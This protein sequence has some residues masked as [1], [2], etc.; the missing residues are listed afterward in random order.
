MAQMTSSQEDAYATDDASDRATLTAPGSAIG[1]KKLTATMKRIFPS[2]AAAI[3]LVGFIVIAT[4]PTAA[5]ASVCQGNGTGCTQDGTYTENAVIN[6]NYGGFEVVWVESV[7]ASYPSGSIPVK[8]TAYLHYINETSSTL[9]LTCSGAGS[10]DTL[11][12]NLSGG[13]G[14]TNGYVAASYSQCSQDPGLVVNVP[15][16]GTDTDW[17]VF[18]NVPWPGTSVSLTWGPAGTSPHIYPFGSEDTDW[19][20]PSFCS[21]HYSQP[22]LS[23]SNW[24]VTPCGQ[25]FNPSGSNDHGPI[26]YQGSELD[27]V[28]FQ[29]VELA[30]RYFWFETTLKPPTPLYAK[31]FVAALGSE[32]PQYAVTS[33]TDTFSASLTPGQLISMGDGTNDSAPGH[34]GVVTAVSVSNGNGTIT[35]MDENASATGED[36]ITVS[37]GKFTT[38]SVGTFADYAWTKNLPR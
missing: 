25:P 27:S 17:A 8:W 22:A 1:K 13:S 21:S 19:A 14:D 6:S 37:G 10:G 12:E 16:G 4:P 20:G 26:Y 28:G 30:A 15:S 38:T 9:T 33:N 32:H 23:Y 3:A 36:T 35:I 2:L 7:V 24:G 29:C 31:D 34:V 5:L 11:V 18:E